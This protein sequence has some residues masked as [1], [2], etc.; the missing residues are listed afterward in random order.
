[1]VTL[2]LWQVGIA[3]LYWGALTLMWLNKVKMLWNSFTTG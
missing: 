2:L 1:M 3:L